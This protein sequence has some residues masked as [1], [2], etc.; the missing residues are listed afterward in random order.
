MCRSASPKV[1][2]S[3]ARRMLRS[4]AAVAVLPRLRRLRR[5]LLLLMARRR[6]PGAV[7]GAAV[8]ERLMPLLRLLPLAQLPHL[9]L[10]AVAADS[11]VSPFKACRS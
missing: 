5:R 10:A 3:A 6:V 2:D 9:R 4:V 11:T 8:V 1:L 7:D